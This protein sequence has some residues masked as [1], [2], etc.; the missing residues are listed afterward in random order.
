M[1]NSISGAAAGAETGGRGTHPSASDVK[2]IADAQIEILKGYGQAWNDAAK[3]SFRWALGA[4]GGGLFFLGLAIVAAICSHSAFPVWLAVIGVAVSEL[5]AAALFW[6][7]RKT[8]RQVNPCHERLHQLQRYLLADA[9][10]AG[11]DDETRASAKYNLVASIA[12]FPSSP[13]V[14]ERPKSSGRG[15]S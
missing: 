4:A 7:C 9:I 15:V 12:G 11:M 5:I 2:Q 10:C 14:C 6:T 1:P 8:V 13:R 3:S